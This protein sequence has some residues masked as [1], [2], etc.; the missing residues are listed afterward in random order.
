MPTS[1][2]LTSKAVGAHRAPSRALGGA[3][4]AAET[5]GHRTF[6]ASSV[7]YTPPALTPAAAQFS[8]TDRAD[9]G[10]TDKG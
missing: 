9:A 7:L 10:P 3:S 8:S 2:N 4:A 5:A 1:T 6:P